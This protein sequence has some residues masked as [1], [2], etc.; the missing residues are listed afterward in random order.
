[1][2]VPLSLR[3]IMVTSKDLRTEFQEIIKVKNVRA[4]LLGNSQDH[5]LIANVGW[6]RTEGILIKIDMKTNG[7]DV[8]AIIDTG[9]QLDV[10]RADVAALKI[11]QAVDMSQVTNMNDA[12]GGRGQLQG[13]IRDVEFTCG[14]AVTATDL[15]VS[16]K[17]PFALLL[18]RPWQRG[19]LV[20]IDE[21]EEGTYLIF[22]DRET[23]QPRF[24]LLAVPHEGPIASNANHYQSF[25]FIEA[26]D[27][28]KS[29]W[30]TPREKAFIER[31]SRIGSLLGRAT[32]ALRV[33]GLQKLVSQYT[34]EERNKVSQAREDGL[35]REGI[36]IVQ[37]ALGA[38]IV[39]G[40]LVWYQRLRTEN[41][42]Q[43]KPVYKE[44]GRHTFLTPDFPAKFAR[45]MSFSKAL[46]E[47]GLSGGHGSLLG[48]LEDVQ[49]LSR[50]Q[51]R[52]PP[53]PVA[54][55]NAS[56]PIATI[57]DGIVRQWQKYVDRQPI[58]V[59]PVF[60]VAPQHEY[61]GKVVLPSGQ[62]LHRSSSYNVFRVF[63]DRETGLPFTM[64]C[65][66]F[67]F[68]LTAPHDP[69]QE[70][71]LE[72]CYPSDER[73]REVMAGMTPLHP[74]GADIG[75]PVHATRYP[76][77]MIPMSERL[78]LN[79]VRRTNFSRTLVI[80]QLQ[81]SP[82]G[83]APAAHVVSPEPTTVDPRRILARDALTASPEP[84]TMR[85]L[86][87]IKERYQVLDEGVRQ[88]AAVGLGLEDDL[89]SSTDSL[90]ELVPIQPYP[91]LES[92][93]CGKC[94]EP[95]HLAE[96]ECPL[97]GDQSPPK[98]SIVTDSGSSIPGMWD[99]RNFTR[100]RFMWSPLDEPVHSLEM[101]RLL[102]EAL[103]PT[104]SEW[105]VFSPERPPNALRP[106]AQETH[107]YFTEFTTEFDVEERQ[108]PEQY[109]GLTGT[110]TDLARPHS[111]PPPIL[112]PIPV[113][114]PL[115]IFNP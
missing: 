63:K 48:P 101:R 38:L 15:W 28:Q 54:T 53:M 13:W 12:N 8:C 30:M 79:Q 112:R 104:L 43:T 65:Q 52:Q 1:M 111:A 47:P 92:E 31:M 21:R 96:Q 7:N 6:P 71:R 103:G 68:H 29:S 86:E 51:F 107:R 56:G 64:S 22:K 55:L 113:Y 33:N 81:D 61:Y 14:G 98:R 39:L 59:D 42:S 2:E 87:V 41:K 115:P 95:K 94:Y 102:E 44:R 58:D 23:R 73:L 100:Q 76:P 46:R 69:G 60:M 83:G 20:S 114:A 49:Y 32:H 4:V 16:Q 57:Q 99:F 18:G 17:A 19:N 97:F 84:M 80:Y 10:V 70:W 110:A 74:Q 88:R 85:D 91:Q 108:A 40:A 9:S 27:S 106:V 25:A 89:F 77:P 24:E 50:Q 37:A 11:Q 75:F 78:R 90:P 35:V 5:P 82:D 67:T 109:G 105:M 3:E 45:T 34:K 62:E 72:L 26:D 93:L 66:E 36:L